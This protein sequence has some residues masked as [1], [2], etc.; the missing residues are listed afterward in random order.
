[1]I[2]PLSVS[3]LWLLLSSITVAQ[4][5]ARVQ[6]VEAEL[7]QLAPSAW[8]PGTVIN[9]DHAY[10]AAEQPGRLLEVANVGREADE[11]EELVRFDDTLLRQQVVADQAAVR[12]ERAR[13]EL[14]RKEVSRLQR[15]AQQNNAARNQLDQA[16][17]DRAVAESELAAARATLEVSQE[18]LR[19]SRIVAPFSGMVTERLL[20]P[21]EWADVG[22]PVLRFV[23]LNAREI[24]AFIPNIHLSYLARGDLLEIRS[25]AE[26]S[27]AEVISLVPVGDE[28]SRLYELRVAVPEPRWLAGLSVQIAAPLDQVQ[29]AVV[30]PRDA[31]VLRR[32]GTS[33]FRIGDG[34]VAER[35]SV[36]TGAAEGE[37]IEVSAIQPGD[38]V[39]TR[40]G[41]R[42]QPG[43]AVTV[44]P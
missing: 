24:Q 4:P 10:L 15:L 5:P 17:A 21:G 28:R 20:V 8:V 41:E 13:L 2:R 12:R 1:M 33:V 31:L 11:G 27:R 9:R 43:Q 35:V 18:R 37:L 22:D 6:V 26:S 23:D 40:G 14:A 7:R 44:T 39:V 38:R 16:L 34:D 19:R 42:L 3:I 25:A 30:I 36:E 29:E 32:D